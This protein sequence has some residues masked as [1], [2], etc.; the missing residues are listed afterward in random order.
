MY[1]TFGN[2]AR[3]VCVCFLVLYSV[4]LL[5]S[6]IQAPQSRL[7]WLVGKVP[8]ELFEISASSR[9]CQ[10]QI[11]WRHLE[12]TIHCRYFDRSHR[13]LG[14]IFISWDYLLRDCY[15]SLE[16]SMQLLRCKVLRCSCDFMASQNE[17]HILHIGLRLVVLY[18]WDSVFYWRKT[19]K[20]CLGCLR[21]SKHES[22]AIVVLKMFEVF[23]LEAGF[24][25]VLGFLAQR[26]PSWRVT[27]LRF[28]ISAWAGTAFHTHCAFQLILE[29]SQ[30]WY[31]VPRCAGL[32]L[33]VLD[34]QIPK[35]N[36]CM[37]IVA[38]GSSSF[39]FAMLGFSMSLSFDLSAIWAQR[40]VP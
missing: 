12:T 10:R 4:V 25:D 28:A 13:W 9:C 15:I 17:A 38:F 20:K 3:R 24:S 32:H 40:K 2:V 19:W 5:C 34:A 16:R 30:S 26:D 8:G 36:P 6:V 33:I 22:L 23:I 39:G 14:T 21:H 18:R 29:L 27:L 11:A 7:P 35:N 31:V 1:T 37:V